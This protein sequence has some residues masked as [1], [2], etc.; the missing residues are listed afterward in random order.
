MRDFHHFYVAV[1]YP[2]GH[3]WVELI[4]TYPA[5]GLI[6]LICAAALVLI[7]V[8]LTKIVDDLPTIVLYPPAIC[9]GVAIGNGIVGL[10]PIPST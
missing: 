1:D 5:Y 3:D 6:P 7:V 4:K 8:W 10:I 2:G 9:V